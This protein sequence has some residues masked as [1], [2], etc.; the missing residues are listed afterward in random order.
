VEQVES[1]YLK[2]RLTKRLGYTPKLSATNW[3]TFIK[4]FVY[5]GYTV[6]EIQHDIKYGPLYVSPTIPAYKW[7]VMRTK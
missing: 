2:T 3:N 6:A 4:A 1:A 5:G 7:R